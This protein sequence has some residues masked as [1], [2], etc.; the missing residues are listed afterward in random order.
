MARFNDLLSRL[1]LR[2]LLF[3]IFAVLGALPIVF[4]TMANVRIN[5][6]LLEDQEMLNLSRHAELVSRDLGWQV[7]RVTD[8]LQQL[9]AGLGSVSAGR[10]ADYLLRFIESSGDGFYARFVDLRGGRS[11]QPPALEPALVEAAELA[12][13]RGDRFVFAGEV[14]AARDPWVVVTELAGRDPER[15]SWALQGILPLAIPAESGQ[16]IFLVDGESFGVL[17][18][19]QSQE[20]ALWGAI[21]EAPEVREYLRLAAVEVGVFPY[22]LRVGST[23][24]SMIA[25]VIPLS[26]TGWRLLVQRPSDVTLQ[27]VR[28]QVDTTVLVAAVTVLLALAFAA[29]AAELIGRP[30]QELAET[31]QRIAAGRFGQRV[32]P[33]GF[34]VEIAELAASFNT[35]SEHVEDHVRRLRRAV[36]VNRELFLGSLRSLLAAVEA[37]EPYTRGHSER[38]ASYSQAI[39]R[40]LSDSK[41]LHEQVWIAG[42]LHDI[43]KIGIDDRILNKGDVLTHD[44]FEE[45]KRHPVIGAE[46]MSTIEPLRPIV[47]AIRS[48]HER[49]VGGGY[50]DGISG[51]DIPLMAR[52]VG[53]ADTFDALTTQRVYQAPFAPD[54]ALEIVRSLRGQNFDPRVVEAFFAAYDRGEISVHPVRGPRRAP[55]SLT[56]AAPVHT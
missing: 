5:R 19:A 13:V 17:W 11:L 40:H 38:V 55:A 35:M 39:A 30:T 18:S 25:R 3:G 56:E 49:W 53:V 47:P 32:E 6:S 43:G 7:D 20:R 52:I 1:R 23:E 51:E 36:K 28:D 27:A 45:M 26:D 8:R 16:D 42:L 4:I 10:E 29:V 44:E 33:R 34:G 54:E 9:A 37:K 2:H 21:A 48:H 15:P 24:R 22:R 14:G 46:I 50:P 41:T 31:S 12:R